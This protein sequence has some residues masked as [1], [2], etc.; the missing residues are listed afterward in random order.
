VRWTVNGRR[1]KAPAWALVVG[2]ITSRYCTVLERA[3]RLEARSLTRSKTCMIQPH[4]GTLPCGTTGT[5]PFE[6]SN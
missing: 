3:V 4:A 1:F 6:R 2:S 5:T